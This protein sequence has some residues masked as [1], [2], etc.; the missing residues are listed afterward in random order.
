MC[1]SVCAHACRSWKCG[2][3]LRHSREQSTTTNTSGAASPQN[4][5]KIR[6]ALHPRPSHTASISTHKHQSRSGSGQQRDPTASIQHKRSAS[7]GTNQHRRL[8]AGNAHQRHLRRQRSAHHRSHRSILF[9]TGCSDDECALGIGEPET[10]KPSASLHI[11]FSLRAFQILPSFCWHLQCHFCNS[12]QS[13]AQLLVRYF[14][15]LHG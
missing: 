15:V 11:A 13:F 3:E 8:H 7:M 5:T 1:L 6:E 14:F 2:C 4:L 10:G 12:C 9:A